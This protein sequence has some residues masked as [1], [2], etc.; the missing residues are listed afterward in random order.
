MVLVIAGVIPIIGPMRGA[1]K[2][3]AGGGPLAPAGSERIDIRSGQA[4]IEIPEAPKL[5]NFFVPIAVLISATIFFDIDMQMGV[6][7]TVGFNFIFFVL[8]GMDPLDY[9]DEVLRG[10]KNMLLPIVLV[11]LAFSFAE[12]CTRI[13]FISFIV[14]AATKSVTPAMLP[15][16]IFPVFLFTELIIG[17]SWGMF[18]IAVPIVVP[19]CMSLGVDPFI[20]VGAVVSAI[21]GSHCCF[22]S[23]TTI[24]T[25]AA[26]GCDNFRHAITQIPF[27]VIGSVTAMICFLI[28]GYVLY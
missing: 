12:M 19:V 23:D 8:Q 27:S 5:Y 26:T 24:L 11:I 9:V 10:I 18:L 17:N 3:V 2:R 25:A 1:Y 16:T 21:G 28:T 20:A 14:D 6:I 4:E 15:V 13:G 22:Y 7:T